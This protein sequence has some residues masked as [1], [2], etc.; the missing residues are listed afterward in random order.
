[1]CY[2]TEDPTQLE[3]S[4]V[5]HRLLMMNMVAIH[6]TSFTTTNTILDLYSSD[7][8]S[9]FVEGLREEC[10]RVILE[11]NCTCANDVASQLHRIDSTIRESMRFS[12]FGIVGLPRRVSVCSPSLSISF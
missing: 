3:P 9:G 10:E 7:P 4:R 1:M 12:T 6:S 5:A 8:S 11:D 2:E